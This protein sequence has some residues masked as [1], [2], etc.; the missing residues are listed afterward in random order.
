[1]KP[2]CSLPPVFHRICNQSPASMPQ[3]HCTLSHESR[4]YAQGI[5]VKGRPNLVEF[6]RKKLLLFGGGNLLNPFL[7]DYR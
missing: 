5:R 2:L 4:G 6:R 1:M 3:D 7:G